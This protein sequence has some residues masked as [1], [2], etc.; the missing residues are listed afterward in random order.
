MLAWPECGRKTSCPY[1]RYAY[2]NLQAFCLK[3]VRKPRKTSIITVR[4]LVNFPIDDLPLC[5]LARC[6]DCTSN[7]CC[8]EAA[9]CTYFIT[10]SRYSPAAVLS[11]NFCV[12]ICPYPAFNKKR[13][14]FT[15]TLDLELRKKLVKCYIW[16][17]ALYGAETWTLRLVDQKQLE[18]FEMWWWKRMERLVGLIM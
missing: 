2:C 4:V 9:C 11:Y 17:I 1:L 7:Y 18:S 12:I 15:S 5:Q 16:S 6:G 13:T 3:R 8:R 10:K 14:I